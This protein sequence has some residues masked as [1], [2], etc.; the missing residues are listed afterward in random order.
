[1]SKRFKFA[2]KIAATHLL[3]NLLIAA[4]VGAV[5]FGVWYPPPY[6]KMMG[7]LELLGLIVLV[8]VVC[9]PVMTAILADPRKSKKNL[10]KDLAIVGCIQLAALAYGLHTVAEARPVVVAFEVDRFVVL[11]AIDVDK[12]QLNEAPAGLNALSW[13]GVRRIAIRDPKNIQERNQSLDLSLQGI[14]P[15]ARPGW[16]IEDNPQAHGRVRA[17]MQPLDKLKTYYPDSALLAEAVRMS[18]LPETELYY[19]PFTSWKT[20]EWTVLLD[21]D[22]QFRGFVPLDAFF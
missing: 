16:W 22:A 6:H 4:V 12:N 5:I 19:L 10:Y 9:G 7:G 11:S 3:L 17:K 2:L 20:K 18:G 14:E 21:Q 15:S 13:T 8:D 1:M